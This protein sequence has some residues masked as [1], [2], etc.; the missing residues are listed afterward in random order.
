ML[1][2]IS[3]CNVNEGTSKLTTCINAHYR[4]ISQ[5]ILLF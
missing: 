5:Y 2:Q 4:A 1:R 3:N